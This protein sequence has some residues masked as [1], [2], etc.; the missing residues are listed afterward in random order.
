MLLDKVVIIIPQWGKCPDLSLW[1]RQE[2]SAEMRLSDRWRWSLSEWVMSGF[3]ILHVESGHRDL[4]L[5]RQTKRDCN[6]LWVKTCGQSFLKKSFDSSFSI[7][8]P[9]ITMHTINIKC[10][11]Q[12]TN[13]AEEQYGEWGWDGWFQSLTLLEFTKPVFWDVFVAQDRQLFLNFLFWEIQIVHNINLFC[14]FIKEGN[15]CKKGY[16]SLP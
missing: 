3:S 8:W 14:T 12:A 13:K 9:T 7:Y 16:I 1:W 11:K 15:Q 6:P 10:P 4:T 5:Q 2:D